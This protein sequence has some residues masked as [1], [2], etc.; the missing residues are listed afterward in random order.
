MRLLL[1]TH[2]LLGLADHGLTSIPREARSALNQPGNRVFHSVA[3]L[4][5]TAIKHRLG[6]LPLPCPIV[7]W[8]AVL[9]QLGIEAL[10]V[11]TEHVIAEI[12]PWPDTKD[13]FDRLLL[14]VAQVEGMK[15]LTLD[16]RLRAHPLAW[17]PASA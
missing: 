13:P 6:K 17:H 16:D 14:A 2:V 15:L 5:E 12:D 7:E 11:V 4:W 1:D 8:P 10:N 9:Q 3:S